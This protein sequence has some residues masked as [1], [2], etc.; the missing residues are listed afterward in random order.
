MDISTQFSRQSSS[1]HLRFL[2]PSNFKGKTLGR[3][4]R[5]FPPALQFAP[6]Q[7]LLT[8]ALI[9]W[10]N[11]PRQLL[12]SGKHYRGTSCS[13]NHVVGIGLV[14]FCVLDGPKFVCLVHFFA[15][16][17]SCNIM[18]LFFIGLPVYLV[19]FVVL[20]GF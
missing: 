19:R 9:V 1:F 13:R 8:A 10:D 18:A 5:I 15:C 3:H 11:P 6:R 4:K 16:L 20:A 17:S 7:L 2:V 12:G 14:F